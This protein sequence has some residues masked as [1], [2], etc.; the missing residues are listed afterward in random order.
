M[1]AQAKDLW[2]VEGNAQLIIV[3]RALHLLWGTLLCTNRQEYITPSPPPVAGLRL[4]T[5][6]YT[7]LL[8]KDSL[9]DFAFKHLSI[10]QQEIHSRSLNRQS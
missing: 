9:F 8:A 6:L 10:G 2:L 1:R 3:Q 7:Q 5:F 4:F